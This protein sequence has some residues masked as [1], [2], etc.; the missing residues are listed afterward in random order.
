MSNSRA[1]GKKYNQDLSSN[2]CSTA[3][4][5][6][7]ENNNKKRNN[8]TTLSETPPGINPNN[9]DSYVVQL[10][11][12]HRKG[13]VCETN[14]TGHM[15]STRN[16]KS[17]PEHTATSKSVSC[18]VKMSSPIRE[19]APSQA[20]SNK[21]CYVNTKDNS[22]VPPGNNNSEFLYSSTIKNNNVD[23]PPH[24]KEKLL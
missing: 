14:P 5:G 22:W 1:G 7:S 11:R 4:K 13:W 2:R 24:K 6:A 19:T 16:V 23:V 21:V 12:H 3:L 17:L 10:A 18:A 20:R 15:V 9:S 8:C